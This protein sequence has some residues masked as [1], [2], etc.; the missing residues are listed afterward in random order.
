MKEKREQIK[1][2]KE[3]VLKSD[4]IELLKI[5]YFSINENNVLIGN[6]PENREINKALNITSF[7]Q[8]GDYFEDDNKRVDRTIKELT[9]AI[10]EIIKNYSKSY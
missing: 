5:M 9:Y 4:H 6:L 8:D 3:F 2:A 7:T 10:Q 1:I